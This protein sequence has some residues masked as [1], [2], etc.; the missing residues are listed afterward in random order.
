MKDSIW[1]RFCRPLLWSLNSRIKCTFLRYRYSCI[2]P[3]WLIWHRLTSFMLN[4]PLIDNSLECSSINSISVSSYCLTTLLSATRSTR[5]VFISD[6]NYLVLVLMDSVDTF[7]H[8]WIKL[9][10][11]VDRINLLFSRRILFWGRLIL[12]IKLVF[13]LNSAFFSLLILM[14]QSRAWNWAYRLQNLLRL[15]KFPSF[16][17]IFRR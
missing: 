3:I 2:K 6:F 13:C 8:G 10:L 14:S 16:V 7:F 11:V 5:C 4:S 12:L 17:H 1:K 9:I 15:I